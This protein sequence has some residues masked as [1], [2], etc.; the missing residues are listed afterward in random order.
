MNLFH[1][2]ENI[3]EVFATSNVT[4]NL[5]YLLKEYNYIRHGTDI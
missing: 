5:I 1:C 3:I 4:G 2:K